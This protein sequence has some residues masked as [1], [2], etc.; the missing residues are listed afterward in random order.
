MCTTLGKTL[1]FACL[2]IVS[3]G[4]CVVRFINMQDAFVLPHVDTILSRHDLLVDLLVEKF[5]VLVG[6]N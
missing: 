3:V 2:H 6:F 1:C 5:V 4:C